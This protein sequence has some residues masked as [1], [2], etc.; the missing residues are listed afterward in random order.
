MKDEKIIKD[1]IDLVKY[2]DM[3]VFDA[4]IDLS[5]KKG[6]DVEDIVKMLDENL[7]CQLREE[8]VKER[9]VLSI[10]QKTHSLDSLF[11]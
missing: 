8:C 3:T 5:E 4:I 9:K 1:V 6:I 11:V 7:L 2:Y 10:K